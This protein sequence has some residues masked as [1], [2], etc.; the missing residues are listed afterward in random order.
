MQTV[1]TGCLER[2]STEN[3]SAKVRKLTRPNKKSLHMDECRKY[4]N[5]LSQK[6][7]ELLLVIPEGDR[8]QLNHK[9]DI[10]DKAVNFIR[11]M[12]MRIQALE[13]ELV[14]C[15]QQWL[16]DWADRAAR[17]ARIG[18]PLQT[19]REFVRMA[20]GAKIWEDTRI[21]KIDEDRSARLA[22]DSDSE[23][24]PSKATM[25]AVGTLQRKYVHSVFALPIA[26]DGVAPV[27]V[28]IFYKESL[29]TLERL[30][31]ALAEALKNIASSEPTSEVETKRSKSDDG[32]ES[33]HSI[34]FLL[35][36]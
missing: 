33:K 36:D 19:A 5:K 30:A 12:E 15:N 9:A 13:R 35:N 20:G 4:R 2:D 7:R 32:Y 16:A 11:S 8:Q 28:E 25:L 27:V 21:W 18:E 23:C 22:E 17:F 1:T 34:G 26:L 31:E 3:E 29:D 6:F 24:E 10:L 14:L